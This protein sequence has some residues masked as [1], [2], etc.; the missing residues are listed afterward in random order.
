MAISL[1]FQT[2]AKDSFV[3]RLLVYT[4]RGITHFARHTVWV[5]KSPPVFFWHF[6]KR[7]GI[8]SPNF[9]RLLYVP[10]YAG[11]QFFYLII[12][13]FEAH[14]CEAHKVRYKVTRCMVFFQ[15]LEHG[16][17]ANPWG[18]L[19]SLLPFSLPSLTLPLPSAVSSPSGVWG[20]APA[21]IKFGAFCLKI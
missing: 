17:S 11:L 4:Y 8:F 10:I 15:D 16:V 14:N 3:F 1:Q 12:C 9:T 18:P 21:E 7:L 13:N 19:P 6:P 20:G 2:F 5:K